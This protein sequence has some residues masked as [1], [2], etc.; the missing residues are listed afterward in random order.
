MAMEKRMFG[1]TGH[2]SSAILFGAAALARVD[3]GVADRCLDL[4]L[5]HGHRAWVAEHDLILLA[6]CRRPRSVLVK[7]MAVVV[8]RQPC[9]PRPRR[10]QHSSERLPPRPATRVHSQQLTVSHHSTH[11]QQPLSRP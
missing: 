7:R 1:R 11:L 10:R 2:M 9:L 4:L 6:L 5:E 3:Q 8:G